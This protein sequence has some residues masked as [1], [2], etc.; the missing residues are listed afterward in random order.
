LVT[1]MLN[2]SSSKLTVAREASVHLTSTVGSNN[3]N[4]GRSKHMIIPASVS[5][6]AML[7][8]DSIYKD[9]VVF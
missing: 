5:Y 1:D 4:L 8:I 3:L 6:R 7:A 9:N 2:S